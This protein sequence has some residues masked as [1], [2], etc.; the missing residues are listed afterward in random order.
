MFAAHSFKVKLRV[1]QGEG[2]QVQSFPICLFSKEGHDK[3]IVIPLS[4]I[5]STIIF[6]IIMNAAVRYYCVFVLPL[7]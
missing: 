5:T 3:Q 4:S 1:A 6:C 7:Y 2:K